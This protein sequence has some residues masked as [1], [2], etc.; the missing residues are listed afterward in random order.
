MRRI[1]YHVACSLDGFIA[2]PGHEFDWITPEPALIPVLLGGAFHFF[3]LR[4]H[5]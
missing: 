3:P 5:T 4:R 2:G 1:R